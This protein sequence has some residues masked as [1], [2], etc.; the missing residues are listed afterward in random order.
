MRRGSVPRRAAQRAEA[1]D[2]AP[3]RLRRAL[4]IIVLKFYRIG[5]GARPE[6]EPAI[7]HPIHG[8]VQW[9]RAARLASHVLADHLAKPRAARPADR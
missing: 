1:G 9:A 6:S 2:G 3:P 7:W 8:G 5:A 4:T